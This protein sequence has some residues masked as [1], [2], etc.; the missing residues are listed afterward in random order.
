MNCKACGKYTPRSYAGYCQGCYNYFRNGGR[1]HEPPPPGTIAYDSE[2]KVICH[3]CGRSYTRLGSH[4]KESHGMTIAE[5]KEMF[6]LCSSSK[7][8]EASYSAMM[9]EH[10]YKY[11]MPERLIEAGKGTRIKAG[12]THMR[13]GKPIRKQ[14]IIAFKRRMKEKYGK[15][16]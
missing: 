9:H 14:E 11:H 1:V 3:I 13:K 7:T 4:A 12:E 8:T 6:G 16:K 10:A 2:G 5:Y 15:D